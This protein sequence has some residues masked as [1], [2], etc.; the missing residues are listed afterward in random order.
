MAEATITVQVAA[1]PSNAPITLTATNGSIT[2]LLEAV[3][4]VFNIPAGATPVVNGETVD[5][6]FDLSDGDEVAFNKPAGE[7]G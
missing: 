1:G 4:D 5:E 6:D 3:R 2:D 7:K